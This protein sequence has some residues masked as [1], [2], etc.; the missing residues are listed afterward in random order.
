MTKTQIVQELSDRCGITKAQA[1]EVLQAL[2][3]LAE[4]ALRKEGSFTLPDLARFSMKDVPATPE[5]QGVNP[6]TK[7]PQTFAAK[8]ASKKVKA[9]PAGNLKKALTK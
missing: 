3:A 9:A 6:F 5:R 1:K 2:P 4:E 8:P 7:A